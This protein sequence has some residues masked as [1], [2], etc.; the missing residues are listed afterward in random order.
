MIFPAA[1]YCYRLINRVPAWG[2]ASDQ[3]T[4]QADEG[5]LL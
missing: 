5:R 3:A 4:P 2:K 1:D